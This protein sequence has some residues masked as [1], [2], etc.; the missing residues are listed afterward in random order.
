M[1]IFIESASLFS[2]V[3]QDNSWI[4]STEYEMF[5]K[6]STITVLTTGAN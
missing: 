1:R 5:G 4:L 6:G 3:L 2:E